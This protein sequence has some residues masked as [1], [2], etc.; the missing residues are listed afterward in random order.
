MS[1]PRLWPG[2]TGGLRGR[3]DEE[4]KMFVV[5]GSVM[6]KGIQEIEGSK[7]YRKL[8]KWHLDYRGVSMSCRK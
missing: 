2:A 8:V 4:T 1:K 6:N 7:K 5:L 3:G